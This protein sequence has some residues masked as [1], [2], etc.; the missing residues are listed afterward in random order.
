M[1]PLVMM[2]EESQWDASSRMGFCYS[3]EFYFLGICVKSDL[4]CI[5]YE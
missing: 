1:H 3:L 5:G 2:N 4:V